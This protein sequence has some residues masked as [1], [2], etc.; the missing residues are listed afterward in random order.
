[1]L[2]AARTDRICVLNQA[3]CSAVATSASVAD[4]PGSR[5][6]GL[7]GR[8]KLEELE[9]LWIVPCESVHTVDMRYSIGPVY[10]DR[11]RRVARIVVSLAPRRMSLCLRARPADAVR[12]SGTRIGHQLAIAPLHRECI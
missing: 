12:L 11:E 8:P 2:I 9:G 5:R 1:M 10:L 6:L 7:L 3:H 4:T